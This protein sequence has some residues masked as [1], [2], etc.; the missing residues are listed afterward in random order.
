M[1]ETGKGEIMSEYTEMLEYV[2]NTVTDHRSD[3]D[4]QLSVEKMLNVAAK[5][6][7]MCGKWPNVVIVGSRKEILELKQALN[8][9]DVLPEKNPAVQP[10]FGCGAA[11]TGIPVYT[12]NSK[13]ER[14]ELEEKLKKRHGDDVEIMYLDRRN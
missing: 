14:I 6:E 7:I 12:A 5:F 11:F 9:K 2:R 8:I 1:R 3:F 4:R 10:P 13:E